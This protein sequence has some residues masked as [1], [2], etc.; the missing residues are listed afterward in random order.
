[1]DFDPIKHQMGIYMLVI[2]KK[3]RSMVE[4][5]LQLQQGENT[6]EIFYKD[7]IMGKELIHF[8]MEEK[9]QVHGKMAS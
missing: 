2:F 9:T 3:D 4:A 8:L 1:M 7:H 6:K 5:H